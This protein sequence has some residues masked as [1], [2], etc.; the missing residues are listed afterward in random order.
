MKNKMNSSE[1]IEVINRS[2]GSV[3]GIPVETVRYLTKLIDSLIP[4][5]FIEKLNLEPIMVKLKYEHG[6]STEKI[7]IHYL[8]YKQFLYLCKNNKGAKIVPTNDLDEFWHIHIQ[9]TGKYQ[10][11][12]ENIFGSMLHHFPY[13]GMRSKNDAK[14]LTK[15][16][17][18]TRKLLLENFGLES[19]VDKENALCGP[20]NCS[21]CSGSTCDPDCAP[22]E[23]RRRPKLEL[24][25][26]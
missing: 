26:W 19:W 10:K 7:L 2:I 22:L 23:N 6:W 14:N 24:I 5:K 21:A 1:V 18:N 13:F 4:D 3:E 9:D 11:D 20:S 8:F 17:Q 16:G 25:E 15:A 12:C